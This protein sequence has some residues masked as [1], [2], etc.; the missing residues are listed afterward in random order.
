MQESSAWLNMQKSAIKLLQREAMPRRKLPPNQSGEL[1]QLREELRRTRNDLYCAQ[2]AI[3]DLMPAGQQELLNGWIDVHTRK[4]MA[5]WSYWAIGQLL[6]M[7]NKRDGPEMGALK[8]E[9]RAMCPLCDRDALTS[10]CRGFA[11]PVGLERHLAGSHRMRQ[12]SVFNA[13]C[14]LALENVRSNEDQVGPVL[15]MSGPHFTQRPK[16]WKALPAIQ[17]PAPAS[18][19]VAIRP[20]PTPDS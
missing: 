15:R 14:T 7:A 17:P 5:E 12:C 6:D 16:P 13:A 11:F 18:N 10:Y 9:W 20:G 1:A 2:A 8:G 3:I 4:D 19:V